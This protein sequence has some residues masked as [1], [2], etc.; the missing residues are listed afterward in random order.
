MGVPSGPA[1]W[2]CAALIVLAAGCD[3]LAFGEHEQLALG[4][5]GPATM[6]AFGELE[7]APSPPVDMPI[8]GVADAPAEAIV[9]ALPDATTVPDAATPPDAA[10]VD[11]SVPPDALTDGGP[12]DG[13][14]TDALPDAPDRPGLPGEGSHEDQIQSFYAC[15]TGDSASAWPLGLAL[16]ILALR[17]RRR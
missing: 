3:P 12:G 9:D 8:E 14:L 2:L 11:A 1:R 5:G 17:R 7:D 6:D 15:S 16:A 4:D 10:V 13:S